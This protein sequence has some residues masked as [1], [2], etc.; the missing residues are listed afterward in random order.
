MSA[1]L[2]NVATLKQRD[3]EIAALRARIAELKRAEKSKGT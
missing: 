1:R 2:D 3:Q